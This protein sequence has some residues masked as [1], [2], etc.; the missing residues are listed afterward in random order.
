MFLK[1]SNSNTDECCCSRVDEY[2]EMSRYWTKTSNCTSPYH[3]CNIPSKD[4]CEVQLNPTFDGSCGHMHE[5]KYQK[6]NNGPSSQVIHRSGENYEMKGW[7]GQRLYDINLNIIEE[8]CIDNGYEDSFFLWRFVHCN[9]DYPNWFG[10]CVFP[11]ATNSLMYKGCNDDKFERTIPTCFGE[12][13]EMNIGLGEDL[14]HD[15][16]YRY[17]VNDETLFIWCTNYTMPKDPLYNI[18]YE[19]KAPAKNDGVVPFYLSQCRSTYTVA[20]N[21]NN[22]N[23]L[24]RDYY[25]VNNNH[26]IDK[27]K[28]EMK[29]LT[30]RVGVILNKLGNNLYEVVITGNNMPYGYESVIQYNDSISINILNAQNINVNAVYINSI[31]SQNWIH[32]VTNKQYITF[33]YINKRNQ[34]VLEKN[35]SIALFIIRLNN[36]DENANATKTLRIG[37]IARSSND[38]NGTFVGFGKLVL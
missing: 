10:R 2:D 9:G 6:Q 18:Q 14:G 17:N 16:D 36:F 34:I 8:W 38:K 19:G 28:H 15:V 5:S 31:N 1:A 3:C 13:E 25:S 35:T 32:N 21:N 30:F 4:E 22:D 26:N 7:L 23:R 11:S 27:H 12:L 37:W 24:V 33:T 29:S 20:N